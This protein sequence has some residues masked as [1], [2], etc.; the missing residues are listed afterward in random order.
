MRRIKKKSKSPKNV[1]RKKN[2]N[3]DECINECISCLITP[4]G[5]VLC[6]RLERYVDDLDVDCP[7][8]GLKN[9][10]DLY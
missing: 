10:E 2:I 7:K 5:R 8:K 1:K 9:E 3:L 6:M 4:L